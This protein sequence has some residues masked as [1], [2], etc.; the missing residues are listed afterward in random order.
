MASP[1]GNAPLLAGAVVQRADAG[2]DWALLKVREPGKT[3]FVLAVGGR[4]IGL[5]GARP[6]KPPEARSIGRLEGFRVAWVREG[7]VGLERGDTRAKIDATRGGRLEVKVGPEAWTEAEREVPAPEEERGVWL[8]R[9][10][11]LAGDRARDELDAQADR[12]LARDEGGD[13]APRAEGR[14][15]ARRPRP[16]RGRRCARPAGAVARRGGRARARAGPA[17]SR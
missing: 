15:R 17:R 5:T 12:R 6:P 8:A 2:P 10:N 13:R 11:E 1:A 14:G 3:T 9:G 16:D 4:G 7:I